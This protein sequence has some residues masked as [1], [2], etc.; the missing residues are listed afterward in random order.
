MQSN[1]VQ[2]HLIFIYQKQQL[3]VKKYL[4]HYPIK[5][6]ITKKYLNNIL[7]NKN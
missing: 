7:I 1:I 6:F 2:Q 3:Y 4:I 5:S